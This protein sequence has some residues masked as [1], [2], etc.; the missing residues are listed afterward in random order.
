M[1]QAKQAVFACLV[2]V[3]V[4]GL[5]AFCSTQYFFT[6][7]TGST[8]G[9]IRLFEQLCSSY[10]GRGSFCSYS[11]G[12]S[13]ILL[14]RQ[15]GPLIE[16]RQ[17]QLRLPDRKVLAGFLLQ[18]LFFI[19]V[20]VSP[21]PDVAHANPSGNIWGHGAGA[22]TA[23]GSNKQWSELSETELQA[24]VTLGY[25]ELTWD[26][27]GKV[28]VDRLLW[29]DLT[30]SQQEAAKVLNFNQKFWDEDVFVD[31]YERSWIELTE[32]QIKAAKALGYKKSSWN[33]NLDVWSDT[34]TW[35]QL[36]AKQREAATIIG[37]SEKEWNDSRHVYDK[38]WNQ[39]NGVQ[40]EAAKTLGYNE[41]KW[42][43]NK[44]VWSDDVFW[45][46][47][48]DKQKKAAHSLGM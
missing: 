42:N 11:D 12:S 44:H 40:K 1:L 17:R 20:I 47:L 27:D 35:K 33:K 16:S 25:D 8:A 3:H 32:E 18:T 13:S 31:V 45:K 26:L 9:T 23:A 29:K 5:D 22:V 37:Y 41:K 7:S 19:A 48:N 30:K 46:H 43:E 39:L 15:H 14:R 28:P 10:V 21:S 34:V 2:A 6:T 38:D 36:N 24:A 4:G